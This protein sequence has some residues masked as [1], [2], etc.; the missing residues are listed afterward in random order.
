MPSSSLR[1]ILWG[2]S[3]S[4][5]NILPICWIRKPKG[6]LSSLCTTKQCFSHVR[7]AC[8]LR[9]NLEQQ[10][11]D[12]LVHSP[13]WMHIWRAEIAKTWINADSSTQHELCSMRVV[14]TFGICGTTRRHFAKSL[15]GSLLESKGL[16]YGFS[17][18]TYTCWYASSVEKGD[19]WCPWFSW[20]WS[21]RYSLAALLIC[22]SFY[23]WH[24]LSEGMMV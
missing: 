6:S 14:D 21:R 18:S 5:D 20:G 9:D 11:Y 24:Q 22:G 4:P 16:S 15:D 10:W 17:A 2:C 1:R 8:T 12:F 3:S 19:G 13:T 7:E 23:A